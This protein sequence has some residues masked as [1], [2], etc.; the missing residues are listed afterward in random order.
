MLSFIIDA[1]ATWRLSSLLVNENGPWYLFRRLREY[2]GFKYYPDGDVLVRPDNH[3]LS[4]V[5]CCS[6]WI[7]LG[8]PFCPRWIKRLLSLSAAAIVVEQ[9]NGNS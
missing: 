9:L 4:C 8:I 5:W 6:I 1:L 3:V 2:V 7:A